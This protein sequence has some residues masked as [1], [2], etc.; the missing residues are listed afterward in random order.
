[1]GEYSS[2]V[3]GQE[4]LLPTVQGLLSVALDTNKHA[5]GNAITAFG[6]L[7]KEA[8]PSGTLQPYLPSI[9]QNLV[10]AFGKYQSRNMVKLYNALAHLSDG[11]GPG[12]LSDSAVLDSL[13]PPIIERWR[14]FS[15][16]DD[17]FRY[18]LEVGRPS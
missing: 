14:A 16:E 3:A 6:Y 1:M 7:A 12:G 15:D 10:A 13:M 2:W 5:Q 4:S 8:G 11:V 18:L 9:T 17:D